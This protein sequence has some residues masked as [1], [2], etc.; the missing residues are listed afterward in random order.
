[1]KFLEEW[2]TVSLLLC[3]IG[4]HAGKYK[5]YKDVPLWSDGT[6]ASAGDGG[7]ESDAEVVEAAG[8]A[9]HVVAEAHV[10]HT[11][12][13]ETPATERTTKTTGEDQDALR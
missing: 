2:H 4:M 9:S 13:V 8:A 7:T 5:A 11:R 10:T 6:R 1:M 12:V 3:Y